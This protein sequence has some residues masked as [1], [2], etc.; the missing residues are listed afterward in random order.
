LREFHCSKGG[1]ITATLSE[2]D[3]PTHWGIAELDKDNRVLG[4]QEKPSPEEAKSRWGNVGVWVME[5]DVLDAIPPE[6]M[7]SI[8]KQIFPK[9]LNENAPFYG[10]KFSGYWKDIGTP[11][12]YLE[13]QRDVL[14]G[15]MPEEMKGVEVEPNVWAGFGTS[16]SES[17]NVVGPV[18]IGNDSFVGPGSRIVG[19][20]VIGDTCR[21]GAECSIE[22]TIVW[23]NVV[24][25]KGVQV[26]GGIVGA[27]TLI[28]EDCKID[29]G[30][31]I[32]ENCSIGMRTSLPAN[33]AIGPGSVLP[34]PLGKR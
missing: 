9:L 13:A 19:P 27:R 34:N 22:H 1:I 10:Y 21:I 5:P 4:W 6:K 26:L 32:S 23:S 12:N 29:T 28:G 14:L 20:A 3:D 31:I 2:V 8:E 15:R 25:E 17:A 11:A 33:A 7:V 18:V 16:I 30:T 24:L